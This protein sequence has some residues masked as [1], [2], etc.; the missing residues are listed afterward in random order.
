MKQKTKQDKYNYP[1]SECTIKTEITR[2][3]KSPDWAY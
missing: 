2:N 1:A 3:K